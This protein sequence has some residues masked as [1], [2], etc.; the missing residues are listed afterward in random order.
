M[1]FYFISKKIINI[2]LVTVTDNMSQI[3]GIRNKMQEFVV[4]AQI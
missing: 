4:M 1:L 2:W 3:S